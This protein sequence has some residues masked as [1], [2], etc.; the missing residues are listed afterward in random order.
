MSSTAP[1]PLPSP[2]DGADLSR[3]VRNLID[4]AETGL[5]LVDLCT[6]EPVV[7]NQRFEQWLGGRPLTDFLAAD[8]DLDWP[9][10]ALDLADGETRETAVE[11]RIGRRAEALSLLISAHDEGGRRLAAV[12]ARNVSRLR[13][14]EYMMESYAKMLERSER[15][16]RREKE[17]AEKL[18]LNIMPRQIYD[19]IKQ[20]GVSTPQRYDECS[21]LML[22][23]VGFTELS[24]SHEPSALVAELNDIFTA[25]DRIAEPF[26][27]ERI[28]TLG[29]AYIAVCG[30]PEPAPDHAVSIARVALRM[31]RYLERR[32]AGQPLTWRARIGIAS[33]PVVG[34]MIGVQKFVYDIF[35]PGVNLAA[36]LEALS[37]PMTITLSEAMA[38]ALQGRF[39]LEPAGEA[40]I[41][42]FGPQRLYRL[43]G[44]LG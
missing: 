43:T 17:R 18:L 39:R 34:S 25:F 8:P 21:V 7:L 12:E 19:E 44:E 13:Q 15:E 40:D 42:G 30:L 1:D 38:P 41:K 2:A 33:G 37:D 14:L 24:V 20:I 6:G 32:N 5:A 10:T 29:D 26:G 31:T 23:F 3:L 11:V 27:C 36:R 35:G 28:K 16:L 9:R 22:D 4:A